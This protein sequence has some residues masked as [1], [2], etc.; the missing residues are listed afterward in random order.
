MKYKRFTDIPHSPVF[1]SNG[2]KTCSDAY[3][4]F[5][6][7]QL[8]QTLCFGKGSRDL[9]GNKKVSLNKENVGDQCFYYVEKASSPSIQESITFSSH[10]VPTDTKH[11]DGEEG[12][13][14]GTYVEL[15][16]RKPRK[17][18]LSE[19]EKQRFV[20]TYRS[21]EKTELCKNWEVYGWCKYGNTCSFAHG[22][23]ELR[24]R[25]DMHP[26]YKT[27]QCKPFAESGLCLYGKRCLF[28]HNHLTIEQQKS[29]LYTN[30]LKDNIEY[31]KTRM[32]CLSG[33]NEEL[34]DNIIYISSYA[35]RR[36]KIFNKLS[37]GLS[38]TT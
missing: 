31:A 35:R 6:S 23:E 18:F 5:D 15:Q 34:D 14:P 30:M 20:Q 16:Y 27:K 9:E 38:T 1:H 26:I 2:L 37:N 21:K 7:Q 28:I 33:K 24:S 3:L 13:Q 19:E 11:S 12:R 36:L 17:T 10:L 8:H 29:A 22:I 32:N 4:P 25:T